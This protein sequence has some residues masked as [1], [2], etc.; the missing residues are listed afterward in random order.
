VLLVGARHP[1]V[2]RKPLI[3]GR[4][5]TSNILG[6]LSSARFFGLAHGWLLC[7]SPYFLLRLRHALLFVMSCNTAMLNRTHRAVND[8][9]DNIDVFPTK[10]H[11]WQIRR[12]YTRK[13]HANERRNCILKKVVEWSTEGMKRRGRRRKQLLDDFKEKIR[14]WNLKEKAL[15]RTLW[16]RG[17]RR[18]YGPLARQT[19]QWADVFHTLEHTALPTYRYWFG[20]NFSVALI[21][22]LS[23][24][25]T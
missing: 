14:Y 5:F 17:F 10:L 13:K 12:K 6:P 18:C 7:P 9:I 23:R 16:R 4:N 24:L 8:Y 1:V 25:A 19:K 2:F 15:V 11:F 21:P 3:K 20:Y 22:N